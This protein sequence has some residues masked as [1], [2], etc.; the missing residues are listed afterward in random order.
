MILEQIVIEIKS[1]YGAGEELLNAIKG[2]IITWDDVNLAAAEVT[3]T[4]DVD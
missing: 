1:E 4:E 3:L 2:L